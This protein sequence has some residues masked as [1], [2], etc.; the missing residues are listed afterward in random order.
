MKQFFG[1]KSRNALLVVLVASL[2]IHIV[3][4]AIFGTIKFVSDILREERTFE[5]PPVAAAPQIEPE[6]TVN[7]QQRNKST[8][9]PRPPA[10]V[11]NNPSELDIPALDIDVNVS[12]SSVYGR[13]GGGFGEGIEGIRQMAITADL[14]GMQV[15]SENL[16]VVLDISGSAHA[17]LDKTIAEI[18]ANFP[19]AHMVLVVG[20]GMSDGKGALGG[21]GG[22]VPGKPRVVPYNRRGSNDQYDS[23]KRS[24][25][26]QLEDFLRK[27]G[28][29]RSKELRRYFKR[30]DNLYVLY[31][32]D[33]H[34]ANFAFEHVMDLNVDTI[35]WFAD[36]ADS[37]N[38]DTIEDLTKKLRR[39]RVTVIAHNFLGRP[40][41]REAK[42]MVETT[43]GQ[44]IEVVPG[45][46]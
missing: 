4:I 44:T 15:T 26:A 40:V 23:L 9:P 6:Y 11:V 19:T 42:K 5:A 43:G 34:A 37:I 16:G 31:G 21:G 20:C 41:R 7:I 35:Y 3:A 27:T 25:P 33:I 1:K 45:Q 22:K 12:T 38:A 24:V 13:T 28:P 18:D 8:P 30:R 14:F 17:H 32:G 46:Q 36:F 29:E 10:I 2:A 39:N